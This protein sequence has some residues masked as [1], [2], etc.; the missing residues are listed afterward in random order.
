MHRESFQYITIKSGVR[1]STCKSKTSL[2]YLLLALSNQD[3]LFVPPL[4]SDILLKLLLQI[5]KDTITFLSH[6]LLHVF[7]PTAMKHRL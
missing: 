4:A 3:F 5:H 2:F 6:W 7:A 1:Y